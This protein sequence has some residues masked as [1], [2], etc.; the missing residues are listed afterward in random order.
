MLV[1]LADLLARALCE[2]VVDGLEGVRTWFPDLRPNVLGLWDIE[3][4]RRLRVAHAELVE[5]P[6]PVAEPLSR[7][8]DRRPHVEA[9]GVVL[10]GRPVPV[11][12]QET[13]QALV[14]IVH[15]VLPPREADACGIDD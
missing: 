4:V 9:E 10:E 8:E 5:R 13:D 3:V 1:D 2:L 15:L 12:H 14:R 6:D 7:E 11:A